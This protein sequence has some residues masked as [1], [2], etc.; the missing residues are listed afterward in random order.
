ML[1]PAA[2]LVKRLG[3]ETPRRKRLVATRRRASL[4]VRHCFAFVVASTDRA[5]P[6]SCFCL[7]E[8]FHLHSRLWLTLRALLV[9]VFF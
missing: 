6:V 4:L 8:T 5:A 9:S 3:K 2:R 7:S 1:K